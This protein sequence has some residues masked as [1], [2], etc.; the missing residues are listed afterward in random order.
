MLD[1]DLTGAFVNGWREPVD[2]AIEKDDSIGED[3]YLIRTISAV[4]RGRQ[5]KTTLVNQFLKLMLSTPAITV[6]IRGKL[7]ILKI[8][9]VFFFYSQ[10][11]NPQRTD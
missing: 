8:V 1:L 9:I 2:A 6:A 10:T 5:R 4:R 7:V 3:C 11:E